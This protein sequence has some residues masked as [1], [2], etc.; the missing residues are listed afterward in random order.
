MA[1]PIFIN[2]ILC[3]YLA[4]RCK[5]HRTP[6]SHPKYTS[7]GHQIRRTAEPVNSPTFEHDEPMLHYMH[8]DHAQ[9]SAWLVDHRIHREV[10]AHLIGKQ[11]F[12]LQGGIVSERMRRDCI[13]SRN[14]QARRLNR[15]ER[16]IVLLDDGDM[17][18]SCGCDS[19]MQS[20]RQIRITARA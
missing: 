14:D 18:R 17:A 5:P 11:T 7:R 19:M 20:F 8:F 15:I 10:K 2:E 13:F 6:R 1:V 9:R 16:A 3:G 4:Y 12:H